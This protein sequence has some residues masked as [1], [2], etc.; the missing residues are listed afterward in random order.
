LGGRDFGALLKIPD[1]LKVDI[2]LLGSEDSRIILA[3]K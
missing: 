2:P 3:V 1:R